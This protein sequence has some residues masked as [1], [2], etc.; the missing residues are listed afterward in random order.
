M[1]QLISGKPETIPYSKGKM[2]IEV[3]PQPELAELP[4][5]RILNSHLPF[6]MLPKEMKGGYKYVSKIVHLTHSYLEPVKGS[7]M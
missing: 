5:P 1:S 7:D 2:M 3:I 6:H 4:S